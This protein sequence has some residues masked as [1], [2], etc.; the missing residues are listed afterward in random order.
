MQ[1]PAPLVQTA[2]AWL[3][4][5]E[6]KPEWSH[7]WQRLLELAPSDAELRNMGRAWL[8]GREDKPE[9]NYIW[10]QLLELAP[11]DAELRNVG[12]A[13][14]TR[15]E[16]S[17]AW[18]HV[19]RVLVKYDPESRQLLQLGTRFYFSRVAQAELRPVY[20]VA[21]AEAARFWRELPEAERRALLHDLAIKW[22]HTSTGIEGNTY[23]L[24]ETRD[25]L[26][27]GITISGKPLKDHREIDGHKRA[28]DILLGWLERSELF[29][30]DLFEMHS[31]V[32]AQLT[33]D[34]QSP[35]GAW[36]KDPNFVYARSRTGKPVTIEFTPPE[37]TAELMAEWSQ[38]L[39]WW[40]KNPPR[41]LESALEAF[42]ELHLALVR[43]HPFFDGNGR[44]ARLL[45]NL[46]LLK[47]G[48]P[49]L[50]VP[51]DKRD[52]YKQLHTEYDL[53]ACPA[54]SPQTLLLDREASESIRVFLRDA[55][56]PTL[57]MVGNRVIE[58][59]RSSQL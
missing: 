17:P 8:I 55:W 43:I 33:S 51:K 45:A 36:K 49:P 11:S 52:E 57:D 13:W 21:R 9:W 28:I 20:R 38:R 47:A 29:E 2:Q 5:R 56:Q 25:F 27:R 41:R 4:G 30:P 42:L 14:L 40:L 1:E 48:F 53:L 59:W 12:R 32:I 15:R 7:V 34:I 35:V 26:E 16:S 23:T 6:D 46:P 3:I 19:W 44:M 24:N 54:L 18:P 22:T 31:A 39:A 58:Y 10:Q 50:L 37:L